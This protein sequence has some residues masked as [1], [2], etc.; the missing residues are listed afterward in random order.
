MI[1][2]KRDQPIL[3]FLALVGGVI[4]AGFALS[5]ILSVFLAFAFEWL[6]NEALVSAVH[7]EE[8]GYW[9]SVGLLLLEVIVGAAA[10]SVTISRQGKE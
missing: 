4:F 10:K 1:T 8:V 2:I 9:Q 7:V 6:W 5:L 3:E